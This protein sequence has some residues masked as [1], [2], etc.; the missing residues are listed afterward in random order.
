[1]VCEAG[2]ITALP[3][4]YMLP[5][6]SD[7]MAAGLNPSFKYV[8]IARLAGVAVCTITAA[9]KKEPSVFIQILC[10]S[11]AAS[12]KTGPHGDHSVG[13]LAPKDHGQ[14]LSIDKLPVEVG[15]ENVH[16]RVLR[17]DEPRRKLGKALPPGKRS[18][19]IQRRGI[20]PI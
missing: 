7:A 5:S 4:R 13:R 16:Q 8:E 3:V 12:R 11:L 14:L 2:S 10:Q 18:I 15:M 17:Q 6:E 19:E 9:K 1:M 20:D